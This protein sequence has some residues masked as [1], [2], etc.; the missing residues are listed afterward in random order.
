MQYIQTFEGFI[1]E[2]KN[3][4]FFFNIEVKIGKKAF[5]LGSEDEIVNMQ[6]QGAKIDELIQSFDVKY[7]GSDNKYFEYYAKVYSFVDKETLQKYFDGKS[8]RNEKYTIK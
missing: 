5:N 2:S 8:T 4:E 6:F 1:N 3:P 7:N